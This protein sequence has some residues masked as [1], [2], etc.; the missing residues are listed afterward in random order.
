MRHPERSTIRDGLWLVIAIG[1]SSTWCLTAA[2]RLGATFDEPIYLQRGLD[3]WRTGSH[4]GLLRLGTMPLPAD[5]QTLPLYL[6]ECERG[7][8]WDLRAEFTE[9]LTIARV[10]TLPF[11]WLLL[12]Y[13][14]RAGRLIAGS[15][16]GN[17]A[18]AILAC[19]PNLLAHAC[20]ATTDIA[21]TACLLAFLVHYRLGRDATLRQRIVVPGI[22]FGVALV[23]K[24]SA[25]VFGPLGVLAIEIERRIHGRFA[26]PDQ[27]GM[28][29]SIGLYCRDA[30]QIGFI[31]LATA[32]VYC[33]CDWQ[34]EPS[35][36]A[37]AHG[38][39]EG[40]A[41]SAMT[42]V[43]DH[44]RIFSNAGEG[45]ARQ[46]KHNL[47][48]HGV[49]LLGSASD[50]AIWYY[51]PVLFTIKL[52]VPLLV[53]PLALLSL[54]V[55]TL[56]NWPLVAAAIL[57]LFSFNCRVQIGI[58][59]VLP[60]VSLLAI[61]IAG[62]VTTAWRE[63]ADSR[64]AALLRS[65]TIAGIAWMMIG[66]LAAWPDGLRYINELWG[67]RRGGYEIVSD[68]NYDWGQGLPDL[69]RWQSRHAIANLDVWYF[70][71]DPQLAGF[72]L[73]ELPLHALPVAT[74]GDVRARVAG[75]YLAVGTTILYGY[76]LTASH[77]RAAAYLR[78]CRP[79]A[80]TDTFLIFDFTAQSAELA[81][82]PEVEMRP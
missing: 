3:G 46:I 36:V 82:R 53:A 7:R 68:S 18:V 21:V 43:A 65:G 39:P 42:W 26:T 5:V 47:R 67:G 14:W 71:T 31:G 64:A 60:C 16:G 57:F 38:L 49:Y 66:S 25:L 63:L 61:G 52:A 50:H 59:L 28:R 23:A 6:I 8:P 40:S 79:V 78:T 15:W 80:R 70:G 1:F 55:R 10:M 54:R 32:F 12:V 73:H 13:G 19:E 37:W 44:L 75:R 4:R 77:R 33:G 48:G 41:K 69:A 27:R 30:V 9:A 56:R 29:R 58:R 51:F 2:Q 17:L 35:F 11:W 62:A 81:R 76:G 34:S 20:L 74:S 22:W 24:A 45:L 72:D